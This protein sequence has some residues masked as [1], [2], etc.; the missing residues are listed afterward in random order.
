[1]LLIQNVVQNVRIFDIVGAP[2]ILQRIACCEA[3]G[4]N[5][6]GISFHDHDES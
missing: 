2:K 6:E 5:V 4:L 1:M 3:K